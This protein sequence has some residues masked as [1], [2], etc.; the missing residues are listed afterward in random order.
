MW[1]KHV[2]ITKE[3]HVVS[4]FEIGRV[5]FALM[6]WGTILGAQSLYAG[7]KVMHARK[8]SFE[9]NRAVIEEKFGETHRKEFGENSKLSVLGYPDMGNNL[10]AMQ[11]PHKAW[12]TINNAVR[13]HENITY[14]LPSVFTNWFIASLWYPNATLFL[15]INYIIVQSFYM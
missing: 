15:V 12:L 7:H 8:E 6:L 13:A 3:E 10:Y 9:K 1:T 14:R 2:E 11:L 4:R 5:H